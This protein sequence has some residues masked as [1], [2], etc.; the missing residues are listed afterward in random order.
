MVAEATKAASEAT[1]VVLVLNLQS[2]SP[3]DSDSDVADGEEYN[4]CGYEAE[5]HD[6][7]HSTLPK[8]Q[9]EL[10]LAVL[11]AAKVAAVPVAVVLVH[12]GGMAIDDVKIAADAIVDAH[13]PGMAT[14]G[15]A[16]ADLLYGR[17]SPAGKM[18]YSLMPAAFDAMSNFSQFS[19]TAPP[20]R[21]YKYYP[22]DASTMPPALF[23][24]GFGLTYT[25]WNV[26]VAK[27]PGIG[28][29]AGAGA[30]AGGDSSYTVELKNL[31]KVDSD[32]VILVYFAPPAD[33]REGVPT[34]KLQ[35]IDFKR[36]HVA[37]GGAA[38]VTF[39]VNKEQLALP[40][41]NGTRSVVPG[42]Y[43]LAFTNGATVGV[44][45]DFTI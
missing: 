2:V 13:Y 25:T 28:G 26:S 36:V 34:P 38:A 7:P 6:R 40:D 43:K 10:A 21:S 15:P 19:M 17:F 42:N 3:C 39:A 27:Q 11:A 35:L 41:A 31:G 18:P 4:P 29:G 45:V 12:G 8:L 37:A 44:T 16:I 1:H 5:Q 20:G 23:P 32:E 33:L 30:G 14:G 9:N 22:T 24:F